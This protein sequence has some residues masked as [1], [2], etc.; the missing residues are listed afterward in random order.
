MADRDSPAAIF[1]KALMDQALFTLPSNGLDWP[2]YSNSMPDGD[3]IRKQVAAVFDTAGILHGKIKGGVITQHFGI[4]LRIRVD[5]KSY[6][7]GYGKAY[8]VET[9]L[10]PLSTIQVDIPAVGMGVGNSYSIWSFVQTTPIVNMGQDDERR[11]NF[12]INYVM[13]IS[14]L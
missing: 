2:V 14:E 1:V 3:T 9:T 7:A 11:H 13:A 4:Q 8:L 6:Q 5:S 10:A 12:S